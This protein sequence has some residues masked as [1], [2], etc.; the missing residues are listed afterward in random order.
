MPTENIIINFIIKDTGVG[1]LQDEIT[2]LFQ[3]FE[4]ANVHTSAEYGGS[5]LGLAISKQII[6]L[7]GGTIQVESQKWQGSQFS[8]SLKFSC[9]TKQEQLDAVHEKQLLDNISKLQTPNLTGK[10]FLIVED[11]QITYIPRPSKQF[12]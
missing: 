6:E 11:N 2:N 8:F 1:M 4:Q 5:G 3:R 12:V 10:K 7:M 9:I